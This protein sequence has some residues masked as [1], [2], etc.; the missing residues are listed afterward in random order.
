MR[1]YLVGDYEK[2]TPDAREQTRRLSECGV[3]LLPFAP[4]DEE[5]R[6]WILRADVCV[7]ALFGVGLS[8]RID[9]SSTWGRAVALMNDAGAPWWPPISPAG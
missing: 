8:R 1:T 5:A 2:L 7:D 9:P 4:E 6:R 3:A